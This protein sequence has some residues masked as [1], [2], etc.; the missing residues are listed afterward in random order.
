MSFLLIEETYGINN[1]HPDVGSHV[2]LQS[3]DASGGPGHCRTLGWSPVCAAFGGSELLLQT[4]DRNS[5]SVC[6]V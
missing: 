3:M 5:K 6:N 1:G 4:S 2:L